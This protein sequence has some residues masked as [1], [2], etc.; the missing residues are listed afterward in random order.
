MN[1]LREPARPTSTSSTSETAIA[2]TPDARARL[3][4]LFARIVA[5]ELRADGRAPHGRESVTVSGSGDAEPNR[6][7][8]EDRSM[9]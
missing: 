3:V 8:T 1:A 7:V 9:P 5:R 6:E 2:M 4:K